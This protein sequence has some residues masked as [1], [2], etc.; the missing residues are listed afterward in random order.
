H[1]IAA[2]PEFLWRKDLVALDEQ[3]ALEG[4]PEAKY[5]E[6]EKKARAKR[7]GDA[8][9]QSANKKRPPAKRAGGD[10]LVSDS[11]EESS[12]WNM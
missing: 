12:A 6:A 5:T 8:A 9:G 10:M 2:T 7:A 11:D 1:L 3:L 4:Y